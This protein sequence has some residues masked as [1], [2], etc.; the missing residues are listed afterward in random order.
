MKRVMSRRDGETGIWSHHFVGLII[1]MVLNF[2]YETASGQR[3][4]EFSSCR[5]T[6]A[7]V[8]HNCQPEPAFR[9]G[10]FVDFLNNEREK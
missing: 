2:D 9:F 6:Y 10:T 4:E 3:L 8:F 7:L 1:A 5:P